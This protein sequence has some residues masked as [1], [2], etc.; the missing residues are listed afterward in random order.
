MEYNFSRDLWFSRQ[1]E[2]ITAA[3]QGG[4]D[5]RATLAF[6][7]YEAYEAPGQSGA[8]LIQMGDI[9]TG[10]RRSLTEPNWLIGTLDGRDLCVH[11]AD[12]EPLP[13]KESD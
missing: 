5:L 4:C 2:A 12:V 3:I 6:K 8:I 10:A 1:K 13:P 7:T 11:M 9:I